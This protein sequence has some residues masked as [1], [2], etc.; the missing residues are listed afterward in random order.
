MI[1]NLINNE[2]TKALNCIKK[3]IKVNFLVEKSK[4]IQFG[5]FST[6]VALVSSKILNKNPM[7]IAELLTSELRK[8]IFFKDINVTKPGFINLFLSD[9]INEKL[10]NNILE[11]K[12]DFG[13]FPII[14]NDIYSVEYVSANPTGYLHVGHARNAVLGNCLI[15]LLQWSGHNVISEYVVNDAGNQ[16]NNLATAVLIR[17]LQ[18][19]DIDIELPEDSYHGNEII[20]VAKA[21]K[22]KYQDKFVNLKIDENNQIIDKDARFEIRWFARDF[23]LDIIKKDLK[24]LGVEIEYYY[25]EYETHKKNLIPK[26]I[27]DLEEKKV[28]YKKDG[29]IWLK[30]TNYGDDKDRV[31]I[32]SDGTP[33]YFAP[34]IYYHNYKLKNHGTKYVINIWG[35]D[36]YSYIVRMRAALLCL[37]YSEEQFK[38]VC[39]QM[40]RLVKNG[41]EYKMSKRTGQSL[42]CRDLI[43]TLTKDVARWFLISQ[44]AN[45]HI[46]ID[47]DIATKKDNSNPFYYVQY[48]YARGIALLNKEKVEK[49][50]SF[51][52]LNSEIEREILNELHYFKYTILNAAKTYE[53]Y[54]ITVYL[55]NLAKLFHNYYTNNKIL[56]NNNKNK[57]EQYYLIKAVC[58]VVK[59]GLS[60]LGIIALERM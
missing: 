26:L 59:N 60:I 39:M 12:N 41:K 38:V 53:P 56:D 42:T 20:L 4:S 46:E 13:K 5:D 10:I 16:M 43:D 32:K 36:H 45:N 52:N 2:I 1:I 17:Y 25:S 49:P 3:D 40:V 48:A 47:V 14:N 22:D 15:N 27:E 6:N 28:A 33:T 23:L 37:G 57:N 29:A 21:L 54:K 50:K 24:D 9:A 31:L 7:E 30:T 8:S 51:K 11:E 19:F 55:M 34:D 58:Q 44:S 35:S 18:L